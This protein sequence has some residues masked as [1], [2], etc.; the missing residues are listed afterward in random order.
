[1]EQETQATMVENDVQ[2]KP[3]EKLQEQ[4]GILE[5]IVGSLVREGAAMENKTTGM[6]LNEMGKETKEKEEVIT[7]NTQENS[8]KDGLSE[9]RSTLQDKL[10]ILVNQLNEMED[11]AQEEVVERNENTQEGRSWNKTEDNIDDL[12]SILQDKLT[13][14]ENQL[15]E[16][17]EN[18]TE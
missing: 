8:T 6:E 5:E 18:E 16:K 3:Q 1:M 15:K 17:E 2:K 4:N 13:S 11:E 10:T 14:L 12:K 9:L 7:E